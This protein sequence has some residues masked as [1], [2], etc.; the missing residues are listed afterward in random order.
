MEESTDWEVDLYEN[1][2]GSLERAIR[3]L[4]RESESPWHLIDECGVL[5]EVEDES[6]QLSESNT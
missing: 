3:S 1:G 2:Y 5:R 4:E 6:M